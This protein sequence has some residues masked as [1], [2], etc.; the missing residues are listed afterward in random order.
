MHKPSQAL[1]IGLFVLA[2][3]AAAQTW[4]RID[5]MEG[6]D[7]FIDLA[8]L[9]RDGDEVRFTEEIRF[10]RPREL[11]PGLSLDSAT[12]VVRAD[13]RD[14]SY[15]V[16]ETTGRLAGRTVVPTYVPQTGRRE[17]K[18]GTLVH[19]ELERACAGSRR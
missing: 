4:E 8:S 2:A 7:T 10:A 14:M 5:S 15:R 19:A 3:P 18:R 13:C 1:A 12:S 11:G 9:Q 6:V 17:A 16:L